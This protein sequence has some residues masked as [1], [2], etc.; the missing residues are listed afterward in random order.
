[1]ASR[2]GP[3]VTIAENALQ[4]ETIRADRDLVPRKPV[5]IARAVQRSWLERTSFAKFGAVALVFRARRIP[6]TE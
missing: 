4:S 6:E 3:S 5:G 2:Y 1:M